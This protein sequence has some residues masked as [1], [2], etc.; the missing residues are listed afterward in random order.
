M[1][2]LVQGVVTDN[3]GKFKIPL[4]VLCFGPPDK[5][6]HVTQRLRM[7]NIYLSGDAAG[8]GP[9]EWPASAPS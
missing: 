3:K 1:L 6:Q 8:V 5:Q 2:V 9:G 7:G 4:D